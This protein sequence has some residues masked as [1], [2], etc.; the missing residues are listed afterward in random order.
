ME[1]VANDRDFLRRPSEPVSLKEGREVARKLAAWL[2][3]NNKKAGK[4]L[5][6]YERKSGSDGKVGVNPR[7]PKFALGLAAPQLGLL[8]RVCVTCVGGRTLVFINPRII[9]RCAAEISWEEGCLSFPGEQ[10]ETMRAAWVKVEADNWPGP[11]LFGPPT[12]E[13][14]SASSLLASVV[15]QHELDHLDG[16]LIFD[17][18]RAAA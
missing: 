11:V 16:V 9:E 10:V 14:W 1:L 4:P 6:D 18:R 2:E 12:V 7:R 3:R 17:R 8:K 15:V 13:Q 5:K